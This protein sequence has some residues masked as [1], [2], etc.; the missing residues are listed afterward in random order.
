MSAQKFLIIAPSW[1]GDCVMAQPLFALLRQRYPDAALHVF[2]PKWSMAVLK[3]MPEVAEVIEN[4]FGHGD[5]K[6]WQRY[7]CGRSLRA[8]GYA[9]AIVLPGSLKSALVPFF[10]KIPVRS[11][12]LGESRYALLNEI[13]HLDETRLP[14]MVD[15]FAALAFSPQHD[16]L[17]EVPRPALTVNREEQTRS[18]QNFALND[19]RPIAAF[20]PGAEY[21]AAKR[22]PPHH[23]AELAKMYAEKGY[24]I[25]YFGSHKDADIAA[26]IITF[27][28]GIG[29]NLCGKTSLDE[30]I[31]LLALAK[32]VVCNDSGLMHVAAAL[33][34]RLVALYGSS[35][36]DHT[37][38]LT[39]R[40][41]IIS[42]NLDCSPCFERTCPLGHT[43]CLEKLQPQ[44][45]AAAIEDLLTEAA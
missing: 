38:P 29:T 4:P 10:A 41:K 33:G 23:F 42:L 37:P 35:S 9:R 7:L 31:D 5:V 40:A 16:T 28:G 8:A 13:H 11:G 25:W 3:R 6:L 34:C 18:L 22:W 44:Q 39:D 27:S 14:R 17:P 15:R 45:V 43:D 26:Q 32:V 24:Q 1:I 2:A 30:A 21:G 12:F 20:C 19:A 36:P